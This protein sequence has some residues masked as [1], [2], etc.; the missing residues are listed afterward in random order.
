M[1]LVREG[2]RYASLGDN[3][4]MIL[5]FTKVIKEGNGRN[6][7]AKLTRP[8]L[9]APDKMQEVR[10]QGHF[11][12]TANAKTPYNEFIG[13]KLKLTEGGAKPLPP[14]AVKKRPG[15]RPAPPQYPTLVFHRDRPHYR[16]ELEFGKP[17][18]VQPFP[19]AKAAK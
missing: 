13:L 9:N 4:P 15:A 8:Q 6:V 10:Y 16:V 14:P 17:F 18:P 2:A 3:G 1:P 11:E 7:E 19:D 5:E 12:T